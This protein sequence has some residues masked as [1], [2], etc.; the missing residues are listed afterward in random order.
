MNSNKITILEFPTNLGLKKTDFE[1]EP[2]VNKLPV[3]LKKHGFHEQVNAERI[4]SVE[5]PEYSMEFD[6]ESGVRNTDKIIDYAIEQSNLVSEL[7][8]ALK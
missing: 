4:L 3:W 7:L 6:K 5:P 2:G 1:S 8:K